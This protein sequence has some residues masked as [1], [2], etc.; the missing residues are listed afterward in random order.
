MND[1]F[2]RQ[3]DLVPQTALDPLRVTVIGI[4]AIGRQVAL[5]LT[6]L[7]ARRIQLIDFDRVELTNVTSQGYRQADLGQAKVEATK[8]AIQGIDPSTIVETINDRFRARHAVGEAV[9]CCV[10]KISARAAIWRA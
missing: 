9:F 1:R 2:E 7:G 4:G 8:D 6:S 5:Q 3:Q 10:D